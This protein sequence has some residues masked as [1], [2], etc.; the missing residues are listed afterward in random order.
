ME[1]NIFAMDNVIRSVLSAKFEKYRILGDKY[2]FRCNVCGDSKK[3]KSKKRGYILKNRNPWI[4]YCQNCQ[5]SMTVT[6]WLK[7][8]FPEYWKEYLSQSC[9]KQS[10][11]QT[12]SLNIP[13]RIYNEKKDL[14]YFVPILK[15]DSDLFKTAIDL[16]TERLIPTS[17]WQKWYVATDGIFKN[18]LIIPYLD[19]EG[20]IYNYQARRLYKDMEPKY[21]SRIG[22]KW[23]KIYNYYN[24]DKTS[25][26]I[27]FEGVIDSLFAE[28]SI[29]VSGLRKVFD[30][31]V[32]EFKKRYYLLDSDADAQK[33]NVQLLEH[34]EYVFRWKKFTDDIG[35]EPK[36]KWDLNSICMSLK[37]SEKWTF[38]ELEK[39][40]TNSIYLK[41]EF[42]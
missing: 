7:T 27:I 18:R 11:S 16:S 33:K 1:I 39:Y 38:L 40:F 31:K 12:L 36:E 37:R 10:Q 22:D 35:L 23:N 20:K 14:Q 17:I 28:N 3:S 24:A 13:Q 9:K 8:Y 29:A 41:G 5:A 2:N 32:F 26:A 34:G 42:V 15:G 25:P 19:A 21:N 30:S 6:H 4:F